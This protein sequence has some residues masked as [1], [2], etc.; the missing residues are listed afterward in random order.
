MP[1]ATTGTG[2][3]VIQL[4]VP[5]KTLDDSLNGAAGISPRPGGVAVPIAVPTE[6]E[7]MVS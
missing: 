4:R 7:L 5:D 1:A 6:L 2:L 3:T